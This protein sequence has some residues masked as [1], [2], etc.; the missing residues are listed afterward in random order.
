MTAICSHNAVMTTVLTIREVPDDVKE[1]LARD[2]RDHGQ[3]LQGF[4]L[5]VLARQASFSRNR[6]LLTEIDD[7]MARPGGADASAP[8]AAALLEQS[9]GRQDRGGEPHATDSGGG[10]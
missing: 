7:D 10:A 1:A 4:L 6:Q 8:D 9:R 5:S 2:A 3:S